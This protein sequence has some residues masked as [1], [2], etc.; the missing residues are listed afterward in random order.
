MRLG[1]LL[2]SSA[3]YGDLENRI[4]LDTAAMFL[5]KDLTKESSPYSKQ[6]DGNGVMSVYMN[7]HFLTEARRQLAGEGIAAS[8]FGPSEKLFWKEYNESQ[9]GIVKTG[10]LLIAL[11][12]FDQWLIDELTGVT[13]PVLNRNYEES[14][15]WNKTYEQV[16]ADGIQWI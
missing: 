14:H 7:L 12:A 3:R 9:E 8:T 1:S 15:K 10:E 5:A 6:Y 13:H 16:P 11:T 4:S 2:Q